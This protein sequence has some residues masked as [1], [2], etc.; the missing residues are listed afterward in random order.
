MDA[1]VARIFRYD[2]VRGLDC[3]SRL[4]SV[5]KWNIAKTPVG[6]GGYTL[7][8]FAKVTQHARNDCGV[9]PSFD[10]DDPHQ[11]I[12]A[13]QDGHAQWIIRSVEEI[14]LGDDTRRVALY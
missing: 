8:E 1:G 14:G 6:T 5:D 3:Q 10:I 9:E 4:R 11:E 12:R 13:R 2:A 7:Q